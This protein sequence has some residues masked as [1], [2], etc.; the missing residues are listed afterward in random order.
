M[1][2]TYYSTCKEKKQEK[3]TKVAILNN[4]PLLLVPISENA[5]RFLAIILVMPIQ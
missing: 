3:E 2:K 4:L 5:T 1:K